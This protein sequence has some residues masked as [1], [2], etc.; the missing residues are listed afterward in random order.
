MI[1][2]D[3]LFEIEDDILKLF[4]EKNLDISDLAN[5]LLPNFLIDL[6]RGKINFDLNNINISQLQLEEIQDFLLCSCAYGNELISL[7]ELID[8]R[9][10][11][12]KLFD[13]SKDHFR[14]L[15]N[16][17][18]YSLFDYKRE[19]IA[20]EGGDIN[21]L[22]SCIIGDLYDLHND[23]VYLFKIY[24]LN[25]AWKSSRHSPLGC[26]ECPTRTRFRFSGSPFPLHVAC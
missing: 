21:D 17:V 9:C 22:L 3:K 7:S 20:Q 12:W 23:L 4:K 5:Y 19:K 14:I 6:I 25:I 13:K 11:A 10:V 1:T 15:L 2:E 24:L 8:K 18:I 16:L 26:R